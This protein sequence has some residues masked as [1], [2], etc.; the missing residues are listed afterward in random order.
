MT[1]SPHE[2]GPDGR[3]AMQMASRRGITLVEVIV[4]ITI[5]GVLAALVAIAVQSAREASRRIQ[6]MANLRQLGLALQNYQGTFEV[7]PA[8]QG[9]ASQSPFVAIL[10]YLE[11]KPLF[12]SINFSLG[13]T[14]IVEHRTIYATSLSILLCPSDVSPIMPAMTNYAGNLGD[15]A[16]M[17]GS[18]NG[19]FLSNDTIHTSVA[20]IFDGTSHTSAFTEWLL[21]DGLGTNPSRNSYLEAPPDP[22]ESYGSFV[23][24]CRSVRQMRRNTGGIRGWKWF[25]G[26]WE[27]TLYDHGL[28]V[29]SPSC[30][31]WTTDYEKSLR[32]IPAGSQHPG[33]VNSLFLDGHVQFI[34]SGMNLTMWKALG[35]RSGGELIDDHAF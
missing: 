20:D 11:Q 16:S 29:N 2:N 22:D 25:E 17:K 24:R 30:T 26:R 23:D 27:S 10:P 15:H 33:G 18:D 9:A 34:K 3:I 19:V 13:L 14:S 32:A 28:P 6:C 7:Y 5:I 35:T 4:V 1:P 8:G 21:A 31:R 12:D